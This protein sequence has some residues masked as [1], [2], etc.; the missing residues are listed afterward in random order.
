MSQA[1]FPSGNGANRASSW[2]P[3]SFPSYSLQGRFTSHHLVAGSAALIATIAG[4]A[5]YEF[6]GFAEGLFFFGIAASYGCSIALINEI[7]ASQGRIRGRSIALVMHDILAGLTAT[8]T[9]ALAANL[10]ENS[11]L[12]GGI[13]FLYL[14]AASVYSIYKAHQTPTSVRR[15]ENQ[16]QQ[17][18]ALENAG[19]FLLNQVDLLKNRV[20]ALEQRIETLENRRPRPLLISDEIFPSEI[21]LIQLSGDEE[22]S[23]SEEETSSLALENQVAATISI[24]QSM[25]FNQ[26]LATSIQNQINSN[27]TGIHAVV[28]STQIRANV[29]LFSPPL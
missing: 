3:A 1:T 11:I 15:T 10:F 8:I 17:I 2:L 12:S 16:N 20:G 6:S 26:I 9:L 7:T 23:A 14:G 28:V 21:P 13:L 29:I 5:A 4:I 19:F 22:E 24:P 27:T 25:H 18:S